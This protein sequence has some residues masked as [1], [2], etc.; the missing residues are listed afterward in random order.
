MVGLPAAGGDMQASCARDPVDMQPGLMATGCKAWRCSIGQHSSKNKAAGGWCGALGNAACTCLSQQFKMQ[1]ACLA[2]QQQSAS[3]ATRYRLGQAPSCL[4][5]SDLCDQAGQGR[6]QE[7][8]LSP[9]WM[10]SSSCSTSSRWDA[11][12]PAG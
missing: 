3:H 8:V 6:P 1:G 10:P 12:K 4:L 9:E 7:L 11:P 2:A 5:P